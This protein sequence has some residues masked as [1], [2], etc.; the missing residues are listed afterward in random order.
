MFWFS[1]RTRTLHLKAITPRVEQEDAR[2]PVLSSAV[3]TDT[4][5]RYHKTTCQRFPHSPH[6]YPPVS[7]ENMRQEGLRVTFKKRVREETVLAG[8]VSALQPM[9]NSGLWGRAR[10]L[11]VT[12]SQVSKSNPY[13]EFPHTLPLH[14]DDMW[15]PQECLRGGER[16]G[17][18]VSR[19]NPVQ[20]NCSI[21]A[22]GGR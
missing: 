10:G 2:G 12:C 18:Q 17:E 20:A 16:G 1:E 5:N 8:D 22:F 19:G 6:S 14:P 21:R 15:S 9:L 11:R 7:T 4:H 3:H 13:D